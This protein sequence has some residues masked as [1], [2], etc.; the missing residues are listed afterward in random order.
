MVREGKTIREDE[1]G[2]M[3]G[4]GEYKGILWK[5]YFLSRV[6]RGSTSLPL[7]CQKVIPV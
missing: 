7:S 4:G 3:R 1:G 2:E 5:E 6:L